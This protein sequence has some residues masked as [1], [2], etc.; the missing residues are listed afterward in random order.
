[1]TRLDQNRR[2]RGVE[3]REGI[4]GGLPAS[5]SDHQGVGS[6]VY[7]K[8]LGLCYERTAASVAG[9]GWRGGHQ[10]HTRH[11]LNRQEGREV[12]SVVQRVQSSNPTWI[13]E[14][15]STDHT[16]SH[17]LTTSLYQ[18]LGTLHYLISYWS[19]CLT[20]TSQSEHRGCVRHVYI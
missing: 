8:H 4:R 2:A 15:F 3:E 16:P 7:R 18:A 9:R 17:L 19:R 13:L 11:N 5:L 12:L 20:G 10:I 1:M 6:L 14:F